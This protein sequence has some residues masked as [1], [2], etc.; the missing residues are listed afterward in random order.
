MSNQVDDFVASLSAAERTSFYSLTGEEGSSGYRAVGRLLR[1]VECPV[2]SVV[3]ALVPVA[4]DRRLLVRIYDPKPAERLPLFIY[5]HGMCY[6]VG[7]WVVF[8]LDSDDALCRHLAHHADAV[9]ASVGYR[10]GCGYAFPDPLD[11]CLASIYWL[12][13]HAET[14]GAR[15]GAVVLGGVSCGANL[16]AVAARRLRDAGSELAG[17]VLLCPILDAT[18]SHWTERPGS[19]DPILTAD[20][21]RGYWANYV[22]SPIAHADP[23]VSPI[24]S[25]ALQ[26]LPPALVIT[27]GLDLLREEGRAYAEQLR[28]AHNS[29]EARDYPGMVHDFIRFPGYFDCARDAVAEVGRFV[30]RV[31]GD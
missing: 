7:G 3:D 27:A 31:A 15:Q 17:Q 30:R 10:L 4:A 2:D 9:V 18:M 11:D 14:L 22:T 25:D 21:I 6:S 8:A 13:E 26:S 23:D 16:S 29:V 24:F 12:M 20:D 19:A 5:L 1:A 28:E